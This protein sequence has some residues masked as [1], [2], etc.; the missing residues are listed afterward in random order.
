MIWQQMVASSIIVA[1]EL[2]LS[3][4][5]EAFTTATVIWERILLLDMPI[6]WIQI[7]NGSVIKLEVHVLLMEVVLMDTELIL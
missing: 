6:L 4:V 2:T 5:F 7:I 3:L 1:T